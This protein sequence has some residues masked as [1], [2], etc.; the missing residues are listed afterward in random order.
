MML[1]G[2]LMVMDVEISPGSMPSS[3]ISMSRR[4]SIAT[5]HLPTSPCALGWSL[6]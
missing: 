5:P 2:P 6:S 3:R 4:L 1:A